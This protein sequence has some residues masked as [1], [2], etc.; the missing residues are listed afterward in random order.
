M[1]VYIPRKATSMFLIIDKSSNSLVMLSLKQ[2]NLQLYLNELPVQ[3]QIQRKAVL[4]IKH[5]MIICEM[6]TYT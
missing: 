3:K 1:A 6:I 5:D 4:A 2:L